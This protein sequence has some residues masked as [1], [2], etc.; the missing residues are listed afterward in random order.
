MLN[1]NRPFLLPADWP[2]VFRPNLDPKA[3]IQ[4]GIFGGSY[5]T[6][7]PNR[8]LIDITEFPGDW[9]VGVSTSPDTN[10]MLN[11]YRV[12]AGSSQAD[13]EKKGWIH[14]DDPRGWFQWYCRYY[15]GRRHEDDDRQIGRW[16]AFASIRSGRWT[17]RLYRAILN[18]G[19]NVDDYTISPVIRQSL[20]HWAYEVNEL[21]FDVWKRAQRNRKP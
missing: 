10:L 9:F 7:N 21:D 3:C 14:A 11:R 1:S 18:A 4:A 12:K 19:Q 8:Y 6:P 15:L 20:L 5:F 16:A 17:N 2:R 13:W